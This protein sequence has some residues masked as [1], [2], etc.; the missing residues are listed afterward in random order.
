MNLLLIL[1]D[2]RESSKA[3]VVEIMIMA[4]TV[5]QGFSRLYPTVKIFSNQEVIDEIRPSILSLFKERVELE[6]KNE[7]E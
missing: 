5:M 3:N 4:R 7:L 1:F 2:M 6:I